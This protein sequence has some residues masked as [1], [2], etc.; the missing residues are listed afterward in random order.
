MASIPYLDD[1]NTPLAI[2]EVHA[3]VR[4]LHKSS[5]A[6]KPA[7]KARILAAGN[8]LGILDADPEEWFQGADD[9]DAISPGEIEALIEAR[10]QA[11]FDKDY[12]RADAIREELTARGV[13][14]ED[15]S[16]GTRWRREG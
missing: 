5:D 11:K 9:A 3:L 14:L 16:E 10:Q 7:L 15:S 4:E 13:V 1:L 12:G 6:A 8:L 2:A